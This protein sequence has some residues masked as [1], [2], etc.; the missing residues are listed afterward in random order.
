[1]KLRRQRVHAVVQRKAYG[2]F[3]RRGR[4]HGRDWEDWFRAENELRKE[5][6]S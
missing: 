1:V 4:E 5:W 3:E 2:F 6:D